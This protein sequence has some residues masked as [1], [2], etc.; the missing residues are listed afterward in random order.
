MF[1]ENEEEEIFG[2]H[3]TMSK[4]KDGLRALNKRWPIPVPYK[5]HNSLGN[6]KI[7]YCL[8]QNLY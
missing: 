3:G 1:R 4:Q 6:S 2:E 8:F 5:I 7:Y